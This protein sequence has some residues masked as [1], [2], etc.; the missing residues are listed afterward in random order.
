MTI[1]VTFV[2]ACHRLS[3]FQGI[4]E[5][6]KRVIVYSMHSDIALKKLRS[7]RDFANINV[8]SKIFLPVSFIM[9]FLVEHAS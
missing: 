4:A 6:T 5:V 7:S 2:K 9:F 8:P 3:L 1:T